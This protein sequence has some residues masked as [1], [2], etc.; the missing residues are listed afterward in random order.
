VEVHL[1]RQDGVPE[2]C[3]VN[4]DD[5]LTIPKRLLE[6]RITTLS[7][8]KMALVEEA[9]A[10]ALDMGSWQGPHIA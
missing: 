4:L 9:I 5:I 6:E 2:E 7:D 3:V 10:F 8:G 1:S